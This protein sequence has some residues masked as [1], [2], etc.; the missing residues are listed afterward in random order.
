LKVV[1]AI[2]DA[3]NSPPPSPEFLSYEVKDQSTAWPLSV[4][5]G[6]IG[7]AGSSASKWT[8]QG[9]DEDIFDTSL[10]LAPSG[11]SDSDILRWRSSVT[12]GASPEIATKNGG[13]HDAV[14]VDDINSNR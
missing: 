2:W 5:S 6:T 3:L 8:R 14:S 10:T 11:L 4:V 12:Y 13:H 9:D 1:K 7:L